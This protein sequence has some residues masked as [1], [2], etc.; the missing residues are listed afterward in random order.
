MY[1]IEQH[2]QSPPN[3]RLQPARRLLCL[4]S[5]HASVHHLAMPKCEGSA[6]VPLKRGVGRH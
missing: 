1:A 3:K 4:E 6:G 5:A 2:A